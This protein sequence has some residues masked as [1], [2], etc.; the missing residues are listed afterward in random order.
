MDEQD[1]KI[2][3]KADKEKLASRLLAIISALALLVLIVLELSKAEHNYTIALSCFSFVA[4]SASY[5][6]RWV[7]I[8]KEELLALLH[9]QINQ[10]AKTLERWVK[11]KNKT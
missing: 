11:L 2:I 7:T 3:L 9:K 5:G 4:L 8:R 10:D 1:L 6:S